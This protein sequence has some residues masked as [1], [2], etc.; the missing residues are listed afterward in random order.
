MWPKVEFLRSSIKIRKKGGLYHFEAVP[1]RC[2]S[3]NSLRA[4]CR[5][6]DKLPNKKESRHQFGVPNT[7]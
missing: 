6:L 4:Q 5:L 2:Q 1:L 3:A 7:S